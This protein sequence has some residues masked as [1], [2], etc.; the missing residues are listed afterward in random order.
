[1]KNLSKFLS[2]HLNY[3]FYSITINC[4]TKTNILKIII[5][6]KKSMA[7]DTLTLEKNKNIT[8][9]TIINQKN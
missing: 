9:K 1:M 4:L 7:S 6:A 5:I 2:I 8:E 3:F